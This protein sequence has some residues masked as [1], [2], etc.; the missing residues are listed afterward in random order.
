[1]SDVITERTQLDYGRVVYLT[2]ADVRGLGID[3]CGHEGV[4]R[5]FTSFRRADSSGML[6]N[7]QHPDGSRCFTA[8]R[9][10]NGKW[11]PMSYDE[12]AA[13]VEAEADEHDKSL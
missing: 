6:I 13:M 7:F 12:Y 4:S 3:S 9:E 1:M 8:F 11:S 2:C 5:Q 10:E